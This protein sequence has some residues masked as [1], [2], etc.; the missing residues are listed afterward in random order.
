[1]CRGGLA[2]LPSPLRGGVGG[3]GER[4]PE[5]DATPSPTLP[6]KGGGSSL[7]MPLRLSPIS[8]RLMIG[9]SVCILPKFKSGNG[10]VMHLVRTIGQAHGAHVGVVLGKARIL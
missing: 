10:A 9:R 4:A 3:G 7:P 5:S 1:M 6:R 2:L 8:A